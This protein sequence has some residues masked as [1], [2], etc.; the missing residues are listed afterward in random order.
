MNFEILGPA[1]SA[2]AS[3]EWTGTPEHQGPDSDVVLRS[4]NK[5]LA[6]LT[7]R[8][9]EQWPAVVNPAPEQFGEL[10]VVVTCLGSTE[11]DI[12]IDVVCC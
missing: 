7:A 8:E 5:R 11:A 1:G 3:Q 9:T 10:L 12:L 6:A 2:I 4:K